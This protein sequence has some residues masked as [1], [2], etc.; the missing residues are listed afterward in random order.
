MQAWKQSRLDLAEHLFSQAELVDN[1]LGPSTAESLADLLYEI[2]KDLLHKKQLESAVRWLERSL[3]VIG[4]QDLEKLSPDAGELRLSIMHGLVRALIGQ[5]NDA[6]RK[7]AADL[8]GLLE[9]DY[10]DKMAVALLKLDLLA[11]GPEYEAAEY[12]HGKPTTCGWI[13]HE[14]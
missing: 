5:R 1:R 8:V 6:A 14:L 2:G 12:Y 4:E 3:D 9:T 10:G 13:R 11:S 7:R